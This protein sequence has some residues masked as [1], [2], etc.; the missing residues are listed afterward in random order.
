MG[1]DCNPFV[2]FVETRLKI[3]NVHLIRCRTKPINKHK[4][5]DLIS[6][7][8]NAIIYHNAIPLE[9]LERVFNGVPPLELIG[10]LPWPDTGGHEK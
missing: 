9:V 3:M 1:N 10:F 4:F 8:S 7:K 6:I 5:N 2:L